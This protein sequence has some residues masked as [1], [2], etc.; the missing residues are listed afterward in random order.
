MSSS[1]VAANLQP[2]I[3]KF[4]LAM[5]LLQDNAMLLFPLCCRGRRRPGENSSVC[6]CVGSQTF[7]QLPLPRSIGTTICSTE[8]QGD[9]ISPVFF[10]NLRN[11][12]WK[13]YY[14]L[15]FMEKELSLREVKWLGHC[16]ALVGGKTKIISPGLSHDWAYALSNMPWGHF[17]RKHLPLPFSWLEHA[18]P[19]WDV[20][21][22]WRC[23]E[24]LQ[25]MTVFF[26]NAQQ[27]CV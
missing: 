11:N 24:L 27:M 25:E 9:I 1:N 22:G 23:G 14:Y 4:C 10:F 21:S 6:G 19:G 18:A 5:V 16:L 2:H 17:D 7:P 3:I 12:L 20:Y 15:K 8:G 26:R 13:W